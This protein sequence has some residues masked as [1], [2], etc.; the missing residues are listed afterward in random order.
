MGYHGGR[1]VSVQHRTGEFSTAFDA[2]GTI[3]AANIK[4]VGNQPYSGTIVRA[5]PNGT[6]TTWNTNTVELFI[7]DGKGSYTS[8]TRVHS[9][10]AYYKAR[11]WYYKYQ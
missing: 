4:A 3:S 10:D 8:E 5:I 6:Q 2:Y 9:R 1:R 7:P 11:V